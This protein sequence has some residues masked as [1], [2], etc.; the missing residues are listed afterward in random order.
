M[1]VPADARTWSRGPQM[2]FA[3]IVVLPLL[4]AAGQAAY[5]QTSESAAPAATVAPTSGGVPAASDPTVTD[6]RDAKSAKAPVVC[7]KLT[8]RCLG[9]E[10]EP[11]TSSTTPA[12]SG[13]G[14]PTSPGTSASS[15]A[16]NLTPPDIRSVVSPDELKQPLTTPEQ[17]ADQD[18][19]D[20][21]EVKTDPRAPDVPG[22]FGAL[23]WALQHP[24]QA[25]RIFTPV[26]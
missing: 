1:G 15:T 8:M 10:Q 25:W 2:T 12:A 16:M 23:W 14:S 22:G 4:F 5:A 6:R 21:V 24:T 26:E 3:R 19:S 20:T 13:Q 18:E 9:N 7:F 11:G 17:Q